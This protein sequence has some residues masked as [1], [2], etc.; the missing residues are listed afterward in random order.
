MDCANVSGEV[1][2]QCQV[3]G[4]PLLPYSFFSSFA[5]RSLWSR[6]PVSLAFVGG[7]GEKRL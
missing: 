7:V 1:A 5:C 4:K 3:I 6:R 2:C